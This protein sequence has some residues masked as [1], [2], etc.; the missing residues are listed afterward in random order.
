MGFLTVGEARNE[1]LIPRELVESIGL[2]CSYCGSPL[3]VSG[4]LKRLTCS[5][6]YCPKL[7]ANQTENF[8][9]SFGVRDIG[10]AICYDIVKNCELKFCYSILD[11][12]YEF[13]P[14]RYSDEVKYKLWEQMNDIRTQPI[15]KIVQALGLDGID[16]SAKKIFGDVNDIEEFYNVLEYADGEEYIAEKLGIGMG[17]RTESVLNEL[18]YAKELV[19]DAV[20]R[21]NIEEVEEGLEDVIVITVAI[22]KSVK[23]WKSKEAF[24]SNLND[25]YKSRCKVILENS[26]S[27]KLNYLIADSGD[28]GTS[29]FDKARTY[30]IPIVTSE[31]FLGIID[32]KVKE[33]KD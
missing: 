17:I 11:I 10:P 33:V 9:K 32:S 30:N 18:L 12:P 19:I 3:A 15:Y 28:T 1:G 22:T 20:G 23:G 7:V 25:E 8:L 31:Q 27:K 13:M 14:E 16:K 2:T 24:V 5:N 26:V 6:E 29:K 21:F 4:N